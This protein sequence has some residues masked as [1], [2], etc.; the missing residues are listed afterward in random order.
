MNRILLLLAASVIV[1]VLA[2]PPADAQDPASRGHAL[3]QEFCASC[4]AI[5][6]SGESPR[7]GAP[8]FRSLGRSYDLDS[9]DE[10]LERGISAGHPDMP[11]FKF[12]RADALAM[13]A[14]LRAIQ[15]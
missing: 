13:Q 8:P 2:A 6:R 14:Y 12:D 15:R 1:F 7:A 5:G 9:F 4:H 10:R 11:E 3:A